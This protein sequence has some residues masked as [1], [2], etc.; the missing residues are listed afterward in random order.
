M[1]NFIVAIP[2]C[3]EPPGILL[4]TIDAI[5]ESTRRPDHVLIVDNGDR[6]IPGYLMT[7]IRSALERG[8]DPPIRPRHVRPQRNLGCA[9]AWN[10]IHRL[11]DPTTA[12]V[13]NADC[14][15]AHDTFERMLQD[16]TPSAVFAYAYGCFRIDPEIRKVVGEFDEEFYPVYLEDADYR[17]RLRLAGV[18]PGNAPLCRRRRD[19]AGLPDVHVQ[20]WPLDAQVPLWP[21]RERSADGIEHGKHDPEGYQ[22]WRGEKLAWFHASVEKNRA[23]YL[24]KW[25]G[26]PNQEAFSVPFDGNSVMGHHGEIDAATKAPTDDETRP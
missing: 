22:G 2:V 17:H 24:R 9:G 13:L 12:I 16:P 7:E 20:E 5:R 15:V 6:E 14:M 25:G 4:A 18:T 1:T 26:E 11:C 3:N 10:L 21:G 8:E 23:R 19:L